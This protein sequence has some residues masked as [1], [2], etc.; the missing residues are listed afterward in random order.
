MKGIHNEYF[1]QSEESAVG[2]IFYK[3]TK[4]WKEFTT[5]LM[6]LPIVLMLE[7]HFINLQKFERNSQRQASALI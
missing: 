5:T 6:V 7:S 4:I 2:I 1:K 3:S